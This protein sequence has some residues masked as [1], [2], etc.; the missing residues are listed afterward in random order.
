MERI[1]H[2]QNSEFLIVLLPRMEFKLHDNV[3]RGDNPIVL[4]LYTIPVQFQDDNRSGVDS[5]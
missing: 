5:R 4:Q 3:L 1:F 2:Y